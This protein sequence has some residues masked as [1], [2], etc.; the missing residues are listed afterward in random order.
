MD[1]LSPLY[2]AFGF[3]MRLL[4]SVFGNYGVAVILFTIL[5]RFLLMPLGVKQSRNTLKQQALSGELA[6]LQRQYGKDREKMA[7]AQQE[8]YKRH[9]F[10]PFSGC[11]QSILQLF[12][13]WPVYRI[14]SAPLVHIMQVGKDAL[15][16]TE[17]IDGKDQVTGGIAKVLLDLGLIDERIALQARDFN[18]PII[19]TLREGGADLMA[20]VSDFIQPDQ[21]ISLDF[22]GMNLGQIPSY[23][24]L[25]VFGAKSAMYLPLLMIPLL[26]VITTWLSMKISMMT[27]P[28]RKQQEEEKERAKR[29]PAREAQQTKDPT[30]GMTQG[31]QYFMPLFTLF[32]AFTTPAALGLYWI[33]SNI[34]SMVQAYLMYRFITKPHLADQARLALEARLA[35]ESAIAAPAAASIQGTGARGQGTRKASQGK[36]GKGKKR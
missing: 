4:Y 23:Q 10:S 5:L 1:L 12:I 25:D 2:I 36:S 19:N 13:I 7:Q 20:K 31:M 6:E 8:L 29:N 18:I 17:K 28:N 27:M 30:A 22:F 26:S 3:V 24:F 14:I 34:M 9:G 35:A 21:L 33:I 15:A 11:L 16:V 32:I